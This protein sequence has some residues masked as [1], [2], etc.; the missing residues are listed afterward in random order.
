MRVNLTHCDRLTHQPDAEAFATLRIQEAYSS[1][2][3]P[4]GLR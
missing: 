2:P 4:V 1:G 3:Y